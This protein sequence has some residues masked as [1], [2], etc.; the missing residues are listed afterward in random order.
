MNL[1]RVIRAALSRRAVFMAIAMLTCAIAAWAVLFQRSHFESVVHPE[2]HNIGDLHALIGD[3]VQLQGVVT[4]V[5]HSGQRFWVQDE[6]GALQLNSLPEGLVPGQVV[7]IHADATQVSPTANGL[8]VPQLTNVQIHGTRQHKALPVPVPEVFRDSQKIFSGVRMRLTGVVRSFSKNASGAT[9]MTLGN[10]E[11]DAMATLPPHSEPLPVNAV[12]AVTGVGE[13]VRNSDGYV[14]EQRLWVTSAADVKLISAPPTEDTTCSVRSLYTNPDARN[15]HRVQMH[16]RVAAQTGPASVVVDD[17]WGAITSRFDEPVTASPGS[18]V[19]LSGFPHFR[20]PLIEIEHAQLTGL[21]T[22][23]PIEGYHGPTLTSVA[24]VHELSAAQ[25]SAAVPARI[26]GVVTF[27]DEDWKLLFVQDRTGGIFL[28]YSGS[29]FAISPGM[30][31]TISGLTNPGNYAPVIAAPKFSFS[32]FSDLPPPAKITP[33]DASSGMLDSVYVEVEGVLHSIDPHQ[34]PRHLHLSLYSSFG[35][36]RIITPP[37]FGRVDD[38]R[39]MEDASVRVRGVCGTIYNSRRQLVGFQLS[40]SSVKHIQVIAAPEERPFEKPALPIA[41]LLHFSPNARFNHRVKVAGTVTVV[42]PRFFYIQD[43]TGGLRVEGDSHEVRNGEYVEAVGYATP[44][45]YSPVLTEAEVH[46]LKHN[47]V[48]RIKPVM[49][50]A[51]VDGSYDSRLV[52]TEGRLLSVVDSGLKKTLVLESAGRTFQADLFPSNLQRDLIPLQEGSVLRLTGICSSE[53]DQNSLYLLNTDRDPELRLIIRSPRD[54]EVLQQASWWNI[55]HTVL[56]VGVLIVVIMAGALWLNALRHRV[57]RQT[58]ELQQATE[59]AKAVRDLV[60]AM[61]EVTLRKDFSGRVSATG[62]DEIALLSGEFNKMIAELNSRDLAKTAAELKLQQQ[63]L[64]DELTGL[65]NRRLLGDRLTQAIATA[66]RDHQIAAVL[67]LDLDGFKLVNDSLG[68][69]IGDILLTHVAQRLQSRIRKSDTLARLGGDEFTVLLTRLHFKE[70]TELVARSLLEALSAPF[71]IENHDITISASIGASIFPENGTDADLLLQQA[72]SAMYAAKRNG[73]NQMMY[74]TPELGSLVRERVNIE[75]QLRGAIFRGEIT[76][77]YQPEFD[78]VSQRLV[79][80]EALARWTHPTL[81]NIPP[82]KFIPVAEETGLIVPLGAFILQ[83]ACTEA[84]R[85]QSLSQN[86]VQ[87]AVN[88]SSVQ[89]MREGFVQEVAD[90]LHRTGLSP[91]LLQIELTESVMLS[92]TGPASETMK[93]LRAM[94]ISIAIDDFGTGYSCFGY[95]PKLPFNALKI[96]R[97]FVKELLTRSEMKA[98][99]HSLV[100]LAHNLNMQVIVEGIETPEQLRMVKALGGNQVQGYLLGRPT[101]DP[102]SQ[103]IDGNTSMDPANLIESATGAAA[104]S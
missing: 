17:Q 78:I 85:W 48:N 29:S 100:T 61:Q 92:G 15:G 10:S 19:E 77:H 104:G 50:Q 82:V 35:E 37:D 87:V 11:G 40:V 36:M 75:N 12:V 103:L 101:P 62:S 59:K 33:Q 18:T 30:R 56:V 52:T 34:D 41:E 93:R 55:Q 99:I 38:V 16:V 83:Q 20:G 67:Y 39:K 66:K 21:S 71:V 44:G 25:A 80:F 95:L 68:H 70:E 42:G 43:E 22:A 9:V 53:L 49:V 4:Y 13:S 31:L 45:A 98:M 27:F 69:S 74:F 1:S 46:V 54:I 3:K 90:V 72:D 32:G 8:P 5:D 97:A 2:S 6:T 86:P 76:V 63:A 51:T 14:L 91:S 58:A 64:T 7:R 79:R 81:G 102:S 24:S 84:V 73:K 57:A 23:A 60:G 89:F 88:V 96:D 94:G 28:P 65:P 47:M 26:T